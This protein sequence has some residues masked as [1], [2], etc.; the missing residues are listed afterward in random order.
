VIIAGD[1]YGI[2]DIEELMILKGKPP[3]GFLTTNPDKFR[4]DYDLIREKE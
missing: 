1:Y 3:G 4:K 2:F